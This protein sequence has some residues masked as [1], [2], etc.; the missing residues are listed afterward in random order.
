M[1]GGFTDQYAEMWDLAAPAI[2]EYLIFRPNVPGNLDILFSGTAIR[3]SA[4]FNVTVEPHVEH[5]ACFH[6]GMFALSAKLFGISEDFDT[7]QRLTRGCIWAYNSTETGIMPESSYIMICEE[8]DN[9]AW[10]ELLQHNGRTAENLPPGYLSVQD[11]RYLLR[12]EAIESVFYMWRTTGDEYWRDAG[13][14]MFERIRLRTRT[15]FGHAAIEN[16]MSKNTNLRD[17][18]ESFWF[19]ETLKYTATISLRLRLDMLTRNL[20]TSTCFLRTRT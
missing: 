14:E 4:D 20:D 8:A 3:S 5:L 13:W 1:V 18:M 11:G 9:C 7:A 12:P 17:E 16:V 19:G 10:D 6:G 15:P 2:R